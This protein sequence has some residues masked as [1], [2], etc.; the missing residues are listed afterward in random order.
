MSRFIKLAAKNSSKIN[1][2]YKLNINIKLATSMTCLKIPRSQIISSQVIFDFFIALL[3]TSLL[4]KERICLKI[5]V[6]KNKTK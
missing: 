1:T 4:K 6:N 3:T 5:K 2:G